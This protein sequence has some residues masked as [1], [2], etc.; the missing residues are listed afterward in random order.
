MVLISGRILRN[1][2]L[3]LLHIKIPST[4]YTGL[5]LRTTTVV[6]AS[7]RVLQG[8]SDTAVTGATAH[9]V[10]AE[11]PHRTLNGTLIHGTYSGTALYETHVVSQSGE[12][13]CA[14]HRVHLKLYILSI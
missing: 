2:L 7:W 13:G 12:S 6:T 14:R 3:F 8:Y 5:I 10:A 1:N 4:D 11:Y 9:A